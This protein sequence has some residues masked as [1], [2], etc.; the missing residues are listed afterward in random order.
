MIHKPHIILPKLPPK[1]GPFGR[2]MSLLAH[3]AQGRSRRRRHGSTAAA[4]ER[5][6]WLKTESLSDDIDEAISFW[7]D[8]SGRNNH[9]GNGGFDL[10][11]LRGG[12]PNGHAYVEF[13]GAGMLSVPD[14]ASLD[15][16]GDFGFFLVGYVPGGDADGPLLSKGA[17]PTGSPTSFW[18]GMTAS[19]AMIKYSDPF[20][21]YG[22]ADPIY[23][24]WGLIELHR[25]GNDLQF[26]ANNFNQGSVGLNPVGFGASTAPLTIAI[27]DSTDYLAVNIAEVILYRGA[28]DETER[29]AVRTYL[30]EKFLLY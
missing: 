21:F 23:A 17:G 9:A 24:N 13:N 11:H 15:F 3:R 1:P 4:A 12:G 22:P 30:N 20:N 14:S 28:V 6:L 19:G 25:I 27:D 29:S 5:V 10:S 16:A 18:W 8:S 26:I 7:D 2:W